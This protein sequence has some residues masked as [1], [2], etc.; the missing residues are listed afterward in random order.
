MII[1][2]LILSFI[3]YCTPATEDIKA[4]KCILWMTQC[5]VDLANPRLNHDDNAEEICSESIPE[6][7]KA[8]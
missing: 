8:E 3:P 6:P 4:A 5:Y 7:L 1:V 2:S